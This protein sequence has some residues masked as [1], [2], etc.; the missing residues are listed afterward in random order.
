M[1]RVR[2]LRSRVDEGTSSEIV[3]TTPLGEHAEDGSDA[4]ARTIGIAFE[5]RGE[6]VSPSIAPLLQVGSDQVI[7]RPEMRIQGPLRYTGFRDD[8]VDADGM[9]PARIKQFAGNLH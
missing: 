5:R 6:M 9:Q 3:C 8:L 7:L 1:T 2:I 4:L